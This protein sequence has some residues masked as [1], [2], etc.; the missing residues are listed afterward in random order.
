MVISCQDLTISYPND[1][2]TLF[3]LDLVTHVT[4]AHIHILAAHALFVVTPLINLL[5]REIYQTVL[6]NHILKINGKFVRND[7]IIYY[8][9]SLGLSCDI[10]GH[11]IDPPMSPP[12]HWPSN[13]PDD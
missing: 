11:F 9:E 4:M 6:N 3:L 13:D 12:P 5:W 10:N 8:N 1:L 7:I 2:T